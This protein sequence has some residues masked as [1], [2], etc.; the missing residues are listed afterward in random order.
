MKGHSLLIGHN[1]R[2][3]ILGHNDFQSFLEDRPEGTQTRVAQ[4]ELELHRR[5]WEGWNLCEE[6]A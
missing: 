1:L 5:P 3:W 2:T 4:P 6:L